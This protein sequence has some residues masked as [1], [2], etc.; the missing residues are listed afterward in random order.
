[1][2]AG[3]RGLV[4]D[5]LGAMLIGGAGYAVY[6]EYQKSSHASNHPTSQSLSRPDSANIQGSK[7]QPV[8]AVKENAH[9]FLAKLATKGDEIAAKT[10]KTVEV[11]RN[12]HETVKPLSIP[13]VPVVAQEDFRFDVSTEGLAGA[14]TS[15]LGY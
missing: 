9:E 13:S 11:V 5:L 6:N 7:Q 10:V 4:G 15:I 12:E 14:L 3:G 1:M 8:I 2:S